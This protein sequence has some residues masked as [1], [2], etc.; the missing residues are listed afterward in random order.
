LAGVHP[1]QYKLVDG[2]HDM[3]EYVRTQG[4]PLVEVD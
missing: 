1:T 2:R 4:L 3:Y